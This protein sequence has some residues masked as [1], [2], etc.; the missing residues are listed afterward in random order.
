MPQRSRFVEPLPRKDAARVLLED[1]DN[2]TWEYLHL[3]R[4]WVAAIDAG[5]A[6]SAWAA[7]LLSAMRAIRRQDSGAFEVALDTI[8]KIA[9]V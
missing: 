7:A 6:E 4:E 9:G 8:V 3:A 1:R 2:W 5:Q